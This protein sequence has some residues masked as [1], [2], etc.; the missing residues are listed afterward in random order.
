M[1]KDVQEVKKLMEKGTEYEELNKYL[2]NKIDWL[3]TK[4]EYTDATLGGYWREFREKVNPYEV[5]KGRDIYQFSPVE[6]EN[7]VKSYASTSTITQR[8]LLSAINQYNMWTVYTGQN[9]TGNP[10]DQI[11]LG[12]IIEINKEAL[13]ESY[14]SLM[15][16]YNFV[17]GLDMSD[18]DRAM[19]FLLR[20]G[21]KIS[22][23]PTLRWDDIDRENMVIHLDRDSVSLVID[24]LLLSVLDTAKDCFAY[25][26][27]AKDKTDRKASRD[28]KR[29]YKDFGYIIKQTETSYNKEGKETLEVCDIY[30]RIDRL[31]KFNKIDRIKVTALRNMRKYDFLYEIY[32]ETGELTYK[33]AKDVLKKL[34]GEKVKTIET[35]A[36]NLRE[37]FTI[38]SGIE[39]K[40]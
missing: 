13:K 31:C 14:M 17:Y 40:R 7:L 10:C 33:D 37:S 26:Y 23:L 25:A 15:D 12:D 16:F 18:I 19:L 30:G 27:T 22:D 11:R 5:I 28:Y 39:F 8:R 35:K 4:K 9:Y 3:C 21:C 1:C 34:E 6:I 2:K 38:I 32:K 24:N 36:Q 29:I 20:Y